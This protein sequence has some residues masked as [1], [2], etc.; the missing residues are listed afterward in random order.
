MNAV[1]LLKED[2]R[3]VQQLF[4]DYISADE[5]DFTRREDLFQEIE[6]SLLAHTEAE[7]QIFYP[8]LQDQAPD[9]IER[10]REEH[11]EVKQLLADMLGY[12]VDDEEFENRMNTLMEKVQM[13]V[14]EEE[15]SNGS[16]QVARDH[17]SSQELDQMGRRIREREQRTEEDLAA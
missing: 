9:L 14:Q 15:G 6:K 13:H 8:A 7:E 12:E 10:S 17:L 2:H 16:F 11:D 1:D 4:S 3:K 5:D